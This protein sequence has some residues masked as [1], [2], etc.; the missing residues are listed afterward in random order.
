MTARLKKLSLISGS[1]LLLLGVAATIMLHA[2][3]LQGQQQSTTVSST[4]ASRAI[5]TYYTVGAAN[6]R[7]KHLR[8]NIPTF[9]TGVSSTQ[10]APLLLPAVV[11]RD[12]EAMV[13]VS[14]DQP[15]TAYTSS[16]AYVRTL[17]SSDGQPVATLAAGSSVTVYGSTTG[18]TFGNGTTWYRVTDANSA[19][20]YIYGALITSTLPTLS[21]TTTSSTLPTGITIG[22]GQEIVISISKQWMYVYQDGQQIRSTAIAT[23]RPG[24]ETPVGTFQVFNKQSPTTFYSRWP[25]GSP[26]YFP[27]T[28]INYALEFASGGYF[29]HDSSWRYEYGP[30][31]DG[32]HYV[33]GYGYETG[34]HGCVNVPLSTMSWLYNWANIGTTVQVVN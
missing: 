9:Q 16:Q 26:N 11:E 20:R 21:T 23:G 30:G 34:S 8:S 12:A 4:K 5:S 29:I 32:Q 6:Q 22:G 3:F 28:H 14:W 1:M 10:Q 25:V 19:S 17:P 33:P 27:P 24:L 15:Y 7:A 2:S 31:A 18:T 13:N